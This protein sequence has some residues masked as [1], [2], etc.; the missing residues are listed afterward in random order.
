MRAKELNVQIFQS[1]YKA[2]SQVKAD[3]I[4]KYRVK[5]VAALIKAKL[6]DTETEVITH[7]MAFILIA[8]LEEQSK[9]PA[10]WW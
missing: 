6:Q 10:P 3:Y 8:S 7:Q 1:I 9:K 2:L 5:P 4:L